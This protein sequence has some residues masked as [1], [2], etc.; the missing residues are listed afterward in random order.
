MS[1]FSA[2]R[3]NVKA[4]KIVEWLLYMRSTELPGEW[5]KPQPVPEPM[6]LQLLGWVSVSLEP[7]TM[8]S[9][10]SSYCEILRLEIGNLTL[11][12]TL[13]LLDS[14]IAIFSQREFGDFTVW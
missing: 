2:W 14:Y 5:Q 12:L 10:F 11:N 9:D 13:L 6:P 1:F 8:Q 7:K 4:C 3:C